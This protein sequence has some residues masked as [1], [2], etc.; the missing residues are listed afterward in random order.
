M[1]DLRFRDFVIE[2]SDERLIGPHGPLRIGHKA[3]RV[4]LALAEHSGHLLTK[5]DL[6]RLA[7]DGAIVSDSALSSVIKELRRALND[8]TTVSFTQLL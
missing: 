4:L 6:F 8:R 7:W 5:D 2:R 1:T 3:F